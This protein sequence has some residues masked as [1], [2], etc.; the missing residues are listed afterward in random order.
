MCTQNVFHS[1]WERFSLTPRTCDSEF[2]RHIPRDQNSLANGAAGAARVLQTDDRQFQ[3]WQD[4]TPVTMYSVYFDG[5]Y[6]DETDTGGAAFVIFGADSFSLSGEPDW[7]QLARCAFYMPKC[8]SAFESEV[9]ALTNATFALM[10]IIAN[11]TIPYSE[12]G[13][14]TLGLPGTIRT[15]SKRRKIQ[16]PSFAK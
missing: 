2:F 10:H 14:S 5:S 9:C 7:F 16:L 8:D 12:N 1:C 11:N 4:T 13:V 3:P 15:G 6:S